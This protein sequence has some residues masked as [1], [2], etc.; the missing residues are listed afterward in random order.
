MRRSAAIRS[1]VAAGVLAVTASA[2]GGSAKTPAVAAPVSPLPTQAVV[3]TPSPATVTT[4]AKPVTAPK[5][6]P[7]ANVAPLSAYEGDP[8]VKDLRAYYVAAARAINARNFRLPA[9][10]ALSTPGR[11]A[12]HQAVFGSE[13]GLYYPGPAPF[14][15][16]GVRTVAP[17]HKQIITCGVDNGWAL[18]KKGGRAAHPL[19]VL[20]IRTDLL[21]TGGR[22]HVDH[23]RAATG[24]TCSGVRIVRRN[25][26]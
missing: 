5:P 3:V 22:W 8:A 23:V 18:T 24:T 21:S 6:K 20:G 1:G 19:S 16:L 13:I 10:L 7:K 15:P 26:A 17:G 12:R 2:C 14:T 9:L 25:F 11:A 4:P